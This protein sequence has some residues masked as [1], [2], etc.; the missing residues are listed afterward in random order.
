M[1]RVAAAVLLAFACGEA[2]PPPE[3]GSLLG[4]ELRRPD[5]PSGMT[6]RLDSALAVAREA[7]ERAPDDVDSIIWL[8]R[9][10]AYLGRYREAIG[11]FTDGLRTHPDDPRLLRHRG[12]RW[13]T[14]RQLDS[15]IADLAAAARATSGQPDQVEDDGM[16]NAAGIPVSTLQTN[17]WYHLGL[18]YYLRGEFSLAWAAYEQGLAASTNPDMTV[19][20]QYWMALVA[21]RTGDAAAV[22]AILARVDR[23]TVLLENGTYH[24]LLLYFQG[25]LPE[26]SLVPDETDPALDVTAAYG[27]AAWRLSNGWAGEADQL[28]R[29]I[30]STPAWPSFGFIAAEAELAR[31][32]IP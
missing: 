24:R 31:Q 30:V 13:I 2:A 27:V 5:L 11:I 29:H 26:D 19:A 7:W 15:A 16:P 21:R 14:V 25:R 3:A 8:G 10:T 12:H 28:F 17:I 23:S 1:N 22:R 20:F 6:V 32:R 9:R 18:A 4:D